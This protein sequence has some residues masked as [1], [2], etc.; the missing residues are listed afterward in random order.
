MPTGMLIQKIHSQPR[1]LTRM[2]PKR[3]PAAAP[4]PP[5]APQI[6]SAL[7]RSAPSLKVVVTIESAAGGG[8][9]TDDGRQKSVWLFPARR[10]GE[11][12]SFRLDRD[13]R[14]DRDNEQRPQ[15]TWAVRGSLAAKGPQEAQKAHKTQ[16]RRSCR[17]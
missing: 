12:A 16:R 8:R 10:P 11:R 4:E 1:Y 15:G 7:L 9:V 5:S 2:P 3:T 17:L 13:S 6:P 14:A